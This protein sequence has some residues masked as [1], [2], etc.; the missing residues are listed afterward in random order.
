LGKLGFAFLAIYYLILIVTT[1]YIGY[2]C[3]KNKMSDGLE[4]A[5]LILLIFNTCT[6]WKLEKHSF[7]G[8]IITTICL[9]LFYG[10]V[11]VVTLF[12]NSLVVAFEYK[13]G[14][15]SSLVEVFS[16]FS[17]L[18]LLIFLVFISINREVFG[19]KGKP[20]DID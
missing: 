19:F 6:A 15:W 7:W 10:A 2:D 9:I 16:G 4:V 13:V 11:A 3:I 14:F 1:I 12:V 17:T 20:T 5:F 18:F 8:T